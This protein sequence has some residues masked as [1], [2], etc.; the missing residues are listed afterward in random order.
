MFPVSIKGVV[1]QR[2]EVL[3]MHNE[4]NEWELPG[5]KIGLDETPEGCLAREVEEEVGWHVQVGPILDAWLYHIREGRDVLIV[6]Y[7]C[8]TNAT[9]PPGLSDEHSASRL[10]AESEIEGLTMPAGYKR[11]VSTWFERLRH[12]TGS[13]L[14]T[15]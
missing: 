9:T 4:R 1:V 10:F 5:G 8:S 15:V 3:L 6:T 13:S 12:E 14:P 7:G 11:S 2:G